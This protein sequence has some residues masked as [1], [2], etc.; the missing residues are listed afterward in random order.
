MEIRAGS[1]KPRL[2]PVFLLATGVFFGVGLVNLTAHA[3]S[4]T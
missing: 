2:I 1:P 4:C 3:A